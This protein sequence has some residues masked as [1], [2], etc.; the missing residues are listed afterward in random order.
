MTFT[1]GMAKVGGRKPGVRNKRTLEDR[2]AAK[3]GG[4]LPLAYMLKVM[5][6]K[7]AEPNRRD[8]MAK[9]AAPYLHAKLTSEDAGMH[10]NISGN[11]NGHDK[12]AESNGIL[13][14]FVAPSRHVAEDD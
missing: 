4:D 11:G 2:E 13:V 6:D 1:P 5:R 14:Q 10:V 3:A 8:D 9:A 7:E 12:S